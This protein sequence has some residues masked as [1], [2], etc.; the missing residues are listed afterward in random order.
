MLFRPAVYDRL[1]NAG[2]SLNM[3]ELVIIVGLA[4]LNWKL[5]LGIIAAIFAAFAYVVIKA[6][7]NLL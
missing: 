3:I 1:V 7:K 5:A 6:R 2:I 4:F